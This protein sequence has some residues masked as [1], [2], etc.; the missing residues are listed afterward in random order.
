MP[1]VLRSARVGRAARS[2]II[3]LL[4]FFVSLLLRLCVSSSI[5]AMDLR[6]FERQGHCNVRS[7]AREVELIGRIETLNERSG[8]HD[9]FSITKDLEPPGSLFESKQYRSPERAFA[10]CATARCEAVRIHLGRVEMR[11]AQTGASRMSREEI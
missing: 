7:R 1:G 4:G 11:L 3:D 10:G 9:F 6:F 8:N 5:C 2:P